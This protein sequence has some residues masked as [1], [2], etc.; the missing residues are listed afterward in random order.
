LRVRRARP[1]PRPATAHASDAPPP[2]PPPEDGEWRD[3]LLAFGPA[4]L[5]AFVLDWA[6][7]TRAGWPSRQALLASVGFGIVLA[8]MLQRALA[9]RRSG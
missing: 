4:I 3:A 1:A 6:L 9:R 5:V 8:L 2:K 7:T